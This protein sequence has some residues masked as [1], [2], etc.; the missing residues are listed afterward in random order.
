MSS[1]RTRIIFTALL[2]TLFVSH[3]VTASVSNVRFNHLS[4]SD[5]LSQNTVT[6]IRQDS[7]GRMWIGTRD[8]LN[9]YDGYSWR[10][11]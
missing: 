3:D 10:W 2:L 4:V 6:A 5:G 8:G 9:C 7:F 1:I 11:D